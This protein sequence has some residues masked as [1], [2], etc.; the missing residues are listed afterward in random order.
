MLAKFDDMLKQLVAEPSISSTTADIDRGNL[1]VI[2][3]LANWL[4][5]LGCDRGHG[6]ARPTRK[7][8]IATWR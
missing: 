6:A 3:H 4:D 7:A 2:E 1:R 5:D 8:L